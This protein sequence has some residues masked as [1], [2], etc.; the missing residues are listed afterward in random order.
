MNFVAAFIGRLLL[1][2]I[3]IIS[4]VN[5]LVDPGPAQQM[6]AHVSLPAGLAL[7]TGVFEVAAGLAIV[8]G[9]WTRLFSLLLAAYCIVTALYFHNNYT[10][11]MQSTMALK[12]VAIAGGFL[13]LFAHSQMRWSYDGLRA[14]RRAD[15]V[16]H[17]DDLR[18]RDA[19][20]QA[21]EVELRTAR[22]E[23]RAEAMPA[24]VTPG[25]ITDPPVRRRRWF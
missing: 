22:A 19:E 25:V 4:G 5:K 15:L 3:F 18:A 21:R 6:L 24:V 11:P 12:N 14:R 2:L 16:A 1:A 10:D 13:C 23:G 8:I 20:L 7:P 17:D 9:V